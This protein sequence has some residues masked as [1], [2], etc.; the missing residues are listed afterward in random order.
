MMDVYDAPLPPPM[1][2]GA[3]AGDTECLLDEDF[4]DLATNHNVRVNLQKQ[5]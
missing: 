3:N 5:R 4:R 1:I 2:P